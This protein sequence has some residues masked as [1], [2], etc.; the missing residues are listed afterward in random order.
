[1]APVTY[2]QRST[3]INRSGILS[4]KNEVKLS[5]KVGGII[6]RIRVDEGQ[7]VKEGQ[8][9]ASLVLD[10][11]QAYADQTRSVLEKAQRDLDRVTKLWN[12]KVATLEQKQDAETGFKIARSSAVIAEFNLKHARI[13]A[14]EDGK[15][16]KRWAEENE[17]VSAGMPIFHFSS[18]SSKWVIRLG[19]ADTEI[20]AIQKG[21]S[22]YIT[23]EVYP[24]SIF[25]GVV[26]EVAETSDPRSGTYEVE[27]ELV[28]CSR[29]LVSGFVARVELVPSSKR[30]FYLVP[31]DALVE[32][33]ASHGY[34]FTLPPNSNRV[35]KI[36]VMIDHF[37]ESYAAISS[38][39]KNVTHAVIAGAAYLKDNTLVDVVTE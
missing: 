38:D 9:L 6:E 32:A 10:E 29:K 24:S 2:E 3:P 19:L 5:F 13:F 4:A 39:L 30:F 36:P 28:F 35:K 23:F 26:S 15:I 31:L 14:P 7:P 21:D 37:T 11:I 8:E 25:P 17:L 20:I 1:L 16:L 34:I 27:T 33:D 18:S 22:A 12:D